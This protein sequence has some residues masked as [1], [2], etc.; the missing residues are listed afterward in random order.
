MLKDQSKANPSQKIFSGIFL[1]FNLILGVA[2]WF[3]LGKVF[4]DG[5]HFSASR[6]L[7][8]LGV[9]VFWLVVFVLGGI[10]V[11]QKKTWLLFSLL[12]FLICLGFF[13]FKIY[14]VGGILVLTLAL[15]DSLRR[16]RR[17]QDHLLR[18]SLARTVPRSLPVLFTAFA[19]M[20]ALVYYGSPLIA[21]YEFKIEIPRPL[22]DKI[23][24]GFSPFL[25]SEDLFQDRLYFLVN[26]QLNSFIGPYQESYVP[27]FLAFGLFLGLKALSFPLV[28]LVIFM[29]WLA[30]KGLMVSKVVVLKEIPV[31]KQVIAFGSEQVT[32]DA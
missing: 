8:S 4:G 26:E 14:F 23:F 21:S 20:V 32:L 12:S 10:L 29:V 16:L 19:L 2:F 1:G 27:L 28:W 25:P 31:K 15:V 17:E 24:Q 11:P 5:D 9:F 22:F 18:F 6:A 3:L 13:G 7:A 30:L